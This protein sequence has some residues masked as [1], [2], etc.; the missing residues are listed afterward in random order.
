M[1]KAQDP[2]TDTFGEDD[3]EFSLSMTNMR[4]FQLEMVNRITK[5]ALDKIGA[6][7]QGMSKDEIRF[8]VSSYYG[9]QEL[10]KLLKNRVSALSK[11]DDP[12]SMF[13]FVSN[14]IEITEKNIQK[15]LAVASGQ[16]VIGQWAESIRG[17]GPVI[18]AGLLA[19]IDMNKAPT[20]G[21]IWRFA[22]LDP[23]LEWLGREKSS[24]L[25]SDIMEGRA[26]EVT[27]EQF[28]QI[29]TAANRK[30]DTFMTQVQNFADS[31]GK[32]S[33]LT[34]DNIVKTLSKRPWNADLKLIC[35]KLGESFV[36][37]SNHPED[38]Y[39]KVYQA[40]KLLET[41]NNESGKYAE[42]A[43]VKLERVGRSTDAYK[44]YVLGK[45]PPAHLHARAK[46]YAVKLFLA[47]WHHVNHEASFGT[48]P[49]K[50]YI[51]NQEGHT[52]YIA[53]PN[54]PMA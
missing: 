3:E 34:K 8:L 29:A 13:S 36:K 15:F 14:G 41:Q 35:W 47:H 30:A 54:W 19:H 33:Y 26:S 27:D 53:P 10:R 22:G 18:S 17:I 1:V 2:V 32:G 48:P 6:N 23:T 40:R 7:P 46:R 39:G 45:L 28:V 44:S 37:V 50:P 20:V 52:H 31:T 11:Q 5:D 9:V 24:K 49:P 42:Q 51:L 25:V 12:A 38:I 43:A 21:H 16:E 4:S